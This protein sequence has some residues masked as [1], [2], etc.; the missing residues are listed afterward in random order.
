LQYQ[1]FLLPNLKMLFLMV[2]GYL[3][4]MHRVLFSKQVILTTYV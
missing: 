1:K 3:C 2:Q 4:E